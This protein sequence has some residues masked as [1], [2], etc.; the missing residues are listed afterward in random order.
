MYELTFSHSNLVDLLVWLVLASTT[1][2]LSI[3]WNKRGTTYPT[4]Q[5]MF[6]WINGAMVASVIWCLYEIVNICIIG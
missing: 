5:M 1:T 6:H 4:I 3:I 2:I